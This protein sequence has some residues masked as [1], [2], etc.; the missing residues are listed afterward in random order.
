MLAR[1]LGWFG[2]LFLMSVPVFSF[3]FFLIVQ[4]FVFVV[5]VLSQ[6]G[7]T[8]LVLS[9]FT[10]GVFILEIHGK[11][12]EQWLMNYHGLKLLLASR[13]VTQDMCIKD[14]RH[15]SHV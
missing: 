2:G 4:H 3:F 13:R 5:F 1:V 8:A 7:Q 14:P 11:V 9:N 6:E 10:L 12:G 15:P